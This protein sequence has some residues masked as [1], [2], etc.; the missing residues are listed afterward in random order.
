MNPTQIGW[1]AFIV[2]IAS[3][4]NASAMALPPENQADS[5][6]S[7]PTGI[8][9]RLARIQSTLTK[10]TVDTLPAAGASSEPNLMA[11]GWANGRGG[12]GSFVN[13]RRGGWGDGR[14]GAGFVNV[15]P[16]RNGWGDGGG[17]WNRRWPDGG[18]F[19][20]RW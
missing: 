7:Q 20:N 18:S 14:G 19:L 9:E 5:P 13:S 15:N 4:S 12:R 6:P 10:I 8:E 17:F 11:L 3:V 1:T 2:A 16:W